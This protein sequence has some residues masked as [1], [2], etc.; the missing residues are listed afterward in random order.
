MGQ[1]SMCSL[2][3]CASAVFVARLMQSTKNS[4]VVE[5][6]AAAAVLVV[7]VVSCRLRV[8]PTM[9]RSIRRCVRCGLV[10]RVRVVV[11]LVHP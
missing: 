10:V 4:G 8:V 2:F 1:P 3:T 9:S 6:S 11:Q 7:G 5:P